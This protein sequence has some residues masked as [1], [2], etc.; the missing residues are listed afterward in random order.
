M[1][2]SEDGAVEGGVVRH[3]AL[4]Y[5]VA[6]YRV[7]RDVVVRKKWRY[8]IVLRGDAIKSK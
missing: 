3:E 2:R 1:R 7:V 4:R 5:G 8:K 6:W